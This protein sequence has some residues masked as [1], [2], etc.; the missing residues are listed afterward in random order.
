M[1]WPPQGGV[2]LRGHGAAAEVA[3]ALIYLAA[4]SLSNRARRLATRLADPRYL[5]ALLAGLA[6]FGWIFGSILSGESSYQRISIEE[7]PLWSET[8]AP[9]PLVVVAVGWWGLG[10]Y[11]AALA[12]K[13]AEVHFLLPA[14]VSRRALIR[15]KLFGRQP[16]V[17]VTVALGTLYLFLL[18]GGR[19]EPAHLAFRFVGLW[20]LVTTVQLHQTASSLVRTATLQQ[21]R[22]GLRRQWLPLAT[23]L[24]GVLTLGVAGWTAVPEMRAASDLSSAFAALAAA[25]SQPAAQAVLLPL[26][27]AL[28]PL[29]APDFSAWSIAL[30]PAF[31]LLA[32]HYLWVL[33]TDAAFEEGAA[34]AGRERAERR[35]AMLQGR[36]AGFLLSRMRNLPRPWF[37]LTPRGRPAVALFW[38]NLTLASRTFRPSTA[39]VLLAV[40]LASYA[41]MRALGEGHREAATVVMVMAFAMLVMVFAAGSI[42]IR[43]DLRTDLGMMDQLKVYPLTGRDV[44]AAELGASTTT[45]MVVESFFLI[46]GLTFL[47]LAGP[48]PG[49]WWSTSVGLGALLLFLPPL[50]AL[51]L[52]A[53]NGLA[54]LFPAWPRIGMTREGGVEQMGMFVLTLL[55]TLL[56]LVAALLPAAT[57]G[58]GVFFRLVGGLGGW[59][60]LP[61][62]VGAWIVLWGEVVMMVVL[63]GDAYDDLDPAD[64]GLLR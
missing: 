18:S 43:N 34:R 51:L 33:A 14:P 11:Q 61:A 24:T 57:F 54:L 47:F 21:G 38:K 36:T 4:R 59:A 22:E 28:A 46:L 20:L 17:L 39:L 16:G 29:F 53:Q 31:A 23:V 35:K 27:V 32:L 10:R 2:T 8:L 55:C 19:M 50:N 30:V 64:A 26:R 40:F 48:A 45:L 15:Y 25:L 63:L 42:L 41:L 7:L 60:V 49:P 6:Y 37:E 44:V 3:R 52:G 13:P 12:F 58:G 9:L 1:S 5:L 62:A 56:F